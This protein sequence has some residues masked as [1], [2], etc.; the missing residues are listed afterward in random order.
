MKQVAIIST[1]WNAVSFTA[2]NKGILIS[3]GKWTFPLVL[4]FRLV[5]LFLRKRSNVPFYSQREEKRK[6][7]NSLDF[8]ILSPA[9]GN[10]PFFP[11]IFNDFQKTIL[12]FFFVLISPDRSQQRCTNWNRIFLFLQ[13]K[14]VG[15]FIKLHGPWVLGSFYIHSR[16][17]QSQQHRLILPCWRVIIWK[18]MPISC[19]HFLPRT[20]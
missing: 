6:W 9:V 5:V 20:F 12:G 7:R 16:S 18:K 8:G 1:Q 13:E 2:R 10:I 17:I 3:L 11:F 15:T 19:Y 14:W 4:N